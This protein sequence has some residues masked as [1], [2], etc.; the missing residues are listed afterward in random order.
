MG[1]LIQK[2]S[3]AAWKE[4][5]HVIENRKK[6]T[7]KFESF[8]SVVN[9]VLKLRKPDASFYYWVKTPIDDREF[10]VRL[11]QNKNVTVL[12]GSLLGREVNGINPGRDFVRIALVSSVNDSNT[13]ASRIRHFVERL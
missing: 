6:Y 13:A 9:P 5:S 7:E 4:E 12:P 1:G 10:A 3:E 2:I 8:Y 11:R